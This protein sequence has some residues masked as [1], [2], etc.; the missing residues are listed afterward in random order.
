MGD[1]RDKVVTTASCKGAV[2][3]NWPL[4]QDEMKKLLK[5]LSQLKNPHTCPH[6]RPIITKITMNDLY[7][8]FK[9]GSYPEKDH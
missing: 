3:A 4:S 6:G 5:D 2:K 7:H 8:L 1:I 9:R